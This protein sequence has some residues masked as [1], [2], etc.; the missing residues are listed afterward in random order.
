MEMT[1]A[2]AA[3]RWEI[4]P[5]SIRKRIQRGKLQAVEGLR[6]SGKVWLISEWKMIELYGPEKA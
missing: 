4:N 2:E 6:K 3:E 1:L 5:G